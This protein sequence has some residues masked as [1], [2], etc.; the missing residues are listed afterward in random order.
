[1]RKTWIAVVVA[2]VALFVV[3]LKLGAGD[4]WPDHDGKLRQ[5]VAV[6]ADGLRRGGPGTLVLTATAAYTP[7]AADRVEHVN[8]PRFSSIALTLVD[9]AGKATPLALT[10]QR[11]ERGST[12][13]TL[14]LPDVPDGDYK[15]H[16]AY[17]TRLGP[18]ELDL[19]LALYAPAR[20]HVITDRPLYEPGNVVRF[21]AVALRAHDLTPLDDRPGTWVV[22]DPSGAVLLEERAP[23][24]PWGV[25]AGSF[26]LDAEADPGDWRVAWRSGDAVDEVHFAVR[27]FTLPRFR[28]EAS[29]ERPFYGRLDKPVVR[30]QVVYSSGAPVAGAQLDL[31]WQAAGAWPPPTAWLTDL[32]PK[33]ATA[34]ANGR[35]ELDLP[36]IP[37]DL[38]GQATLVARISAVDPAGDR[39]EGAASVLM[40]SDRIA[41]SAVT[42]I[43]DGLVGGTNNRVYLRV[44]TPDGRVIPDATIHVK[45]AWQADDPGVDAQL[46]V[47]GVASL[48]LDPGPPVNVVI[49]AMPYRAPPPTPAVTRDDPEELIGGDGATLADQVEL[50]RWLA[51]LAPC[52]RWYQDDDA[53]VQV[54]VRAAAS[55]ALTL[56]ASGA[57]SPLATCVVDV[58]RGQRLP[59]GGERLYSIDFTFTDP[60]LPKLDAS[61]ESA[62]AP[63]DDFAAK[64]ATMALRARDCL[65]LDGDGSLA[66]M[67]PWQIHAGSKEV[68]FAPWVVDPTASE[69]S[70]WSAAAVAC[71]TQRL[72][73]AHVT[74]DDKAAA[75][76]LGVVRFTVEPAAGAGG[77][78]RPQPTTMLGYELLVTADLPDESA[79]RP[80]TRLRL[81]PGT[82]PPLRL[83]VAPVLAAAG[84]L[85]SAELIRGPDFASSGRALP[86][87]LDLTCRKGVVKEKLDDRHQATF[88]IPAAADG[89]CKIEGGGLRALVYVKPKNDLA[90]AIAP[91]RGSYA[92]GQQADLQVKTLV[93]GQGAPAAVGLFG[94][95]DSLGQLVT[96]PDAD[97]LGRV[98]PQVTTTSPAFGS[99]DGQ[100]LTLGRIRG[101]NAAAA[102]VL[103]VGDVPA[104]AE[105]DAVVSARAE[106][107]FDAIEELTDH[108][109]GVLAELHAQTR[110][111]EASAPA[112]EQMKPATMARLWKQALAACAA[113]GEPVVDAYG[114][115]LRLYRLPPDLLALTDP[116]QVVIVG[117]RLP[118]DVEDWAAWVAKEKP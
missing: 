88:T 27:K 51:A 98:R 87:E 72:A 84:D 79:T 17:K 43:G 40:S 53:A 7:K 96:L 65:P 36:E 8:V 111:W 76:A 61:V 105:L 31:T 58:L 75:D 10:K 101:A 33:H 37:A 13:G 80:S 47:D 55:G 63:P 113:R 26:P 45:R 38:D 69:A 30:G 118:E 68:T 52:A 46:D 21:R 60:P 3:W 90:V 104:D 81:G 1:M 82:V 74:L 11:R 35:F 64:V 97:D 93:G 39:V 12:R 110:A 14:V 6:E 25:V 22:T 41:V 77:A 32:L 116:R 91:T 62:L 15:L 78:S 4:D 66:R 54:G 50:D 103:R 83:R 92:P 67:L 44:T 85:V 71:A 48:Q 112:G 49:P 86:K 23:A 9:A 95:D 102:T 94:V 34:A 99:L 107:H 114:R 20:I 19:P 115:K 70:A 2:G 18:G 59:A 57:Q 16:L 5:T 24:G 89:W 106:T 28:V 29:A 109:Y 42:E 108:F 73:G 117:T 100:A 56:V